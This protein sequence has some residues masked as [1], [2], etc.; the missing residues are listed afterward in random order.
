M[1]YIYVL[2][3]HKPISGHYIEDHLRFRL[4]L[5]DK[6]KLPA[7]TKLALARACKQ[8]NREALPIFFGLNTFKYYRIECMATCLTALSQRRRSLIRNIYFAYSGKNRTA[9]L[10]MLGQCWGL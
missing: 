8:I 4:Q 6:G 9:A 2:V 5:L 1:I 7:E 3:S 10:K